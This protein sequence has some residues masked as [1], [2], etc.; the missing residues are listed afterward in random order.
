MRKKKIT[1]ERP[2]VL[3]IETA[4]NCGSVAIIAG[5]RCLG[6]YTLQSDLTYSRRLFSTMA[7]LLSEAKLGWDIVDAIA[8]SIGPGSFTGLRIGMSAAKGLA[9]ARSIPLIGIP[10]LDGLACQ[11]PYA[12]YQICPILDARKKEIYTAFYRSNGNGIVRR[13]SDYL[14]LAPERLADMI[15]EPTIFLGDG[16]GTCV[17]VLALLGEKAYLAPPMLHY[18]KAVA[19]GMLATEKYRAGDFM[20]AASAVPLY[21]RASEAEIT[22]PNGL[23]GGRITAGETFAG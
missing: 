21:V 2:Y 7:M 1:A 8:I 22:F 11:L 14:V 5:D 16:I 13:Q 4:T 23:G 18:P 17:E 12:P 6:E 15:T 20:E 19:V 3:A 10:T 9:L